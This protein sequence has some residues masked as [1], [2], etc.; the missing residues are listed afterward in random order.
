VTGSVIG[1]VVDSPSALPGRPA[2]S[3][4]A[5]SPVLDGF[6]WPAEWE[7]HEATW[8][9]WPHNLETWPGR[10]E[11]AESAF[12]AMVAA[13]W[14]RE[15]VCINV[16]GGA[17]EERVRGKLREGGLDP[18]RGISFFHIRTDDA[19]IRD[20]GP[21]VLT[22]GDPGLGEACERVVLD[23]GFDAWG[24][25]YPPWDHDNAVPRG[26][27]EALGLR[28]LEPG[29]VLEGGSVDGN[30]QG[31][32]L[33][34][35]SC[36]LNPNRAAGGESRT[37]EQMEERL[38]A[39]LGARQVLWLG[40]GIAGDDTDGHIDDVTRFVA[41]D[42]IVT[43]VEHDP[44]ELNH[45]PL[46]KNRRLLAE[47]RTLEGKP[48]DV[49]ELPM[50]PARSFAGERCPASYANFYLANGVALVPVFSAA[51]DRCALETLAECLPGREIV[52]IP[53]EDLVIGLGALHCLTQQLPA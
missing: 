36:L 47:M 28:R 14:G 21:I 29:F 43:A 5:T 22:R 1:P 31:S 3:R 18:D 33:T 16:A 19:W 46:R 44:S 17:M 50:P 49:V 38:S 39:W 11:A 9:S 12:V 30:G 10:L 53:C 20:H 25:K 42:R 2:P 32:V 48:F 15:R 40:D 26:I 7:P 4:E 35:A 34:T 52:G 41:P 51:A 23:F 6:R 8:L 24:G 37:R 45:D 13:L 27:S